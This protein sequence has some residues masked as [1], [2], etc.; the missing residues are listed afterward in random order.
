MSKTLLIKHSN[1]MM[2]IHEVVEAIES[3]TNGKVVNLTTDGDV[4]VFTLKDPEPQ[5]AAPVCEVCGHELVTERDI[6]L[7]LC[8]AC[9]PY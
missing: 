8:E 7:G 5:S 9:Y 2:T 3:L 1:F 6:E 4:L